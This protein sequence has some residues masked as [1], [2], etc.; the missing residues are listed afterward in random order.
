MVRLRAADVAEVRQ[1]PTM[2]VTVSQHRRTDMGCTYL[3]QTIAL[4]AS[5]SWITIAHFGH[6]W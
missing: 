4:H 3:V 2:G 6:R 1:T 5:L